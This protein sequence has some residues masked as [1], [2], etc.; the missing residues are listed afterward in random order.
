[1]YISDMTRLSKLRK[2]E[3]PWV[4]SLSQGDSH[5]LN[6]QQRLFDIVLQ[7]HGQGYYVGGLMFTGARFPLPI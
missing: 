2:R 3:R 7:T 6:L 1:M 5:F 4:D